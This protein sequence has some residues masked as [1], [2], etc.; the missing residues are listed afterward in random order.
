MKV[1]ISNKDIIK[2]AAPISLSILIPQIS[3]LTNTAF[4]GRMG[5]MELGVNGITGIFYLTLSMI[6]Y[7][8]SS[9]IQVQMARR[10][11]EGNNEHLAKTFTNGM[12]LSLLVSLG[13]IML[14][15]WLAPLIFGLSLYNS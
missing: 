5:E 8:L 13:L 7:G 9:G 12:M 4:L 6:G 11:G 14:S 15:L 10:A 3:F 1:S 2:L